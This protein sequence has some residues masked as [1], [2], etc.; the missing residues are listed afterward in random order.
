MAELLYQG[1][2][3]YRIQTNSKMV[4]YIDPFAGS[5]Y[6]LPADIVLITH[7]HFDH[8]QIDLVEKK[9]DCI[10][11]DNNNAR[12]SEDEYNVYEINDVTIEA[13]PA[14]N[15][16]H[17]KDFGVGYVISF[18][19]RKLYIT[20]D[21]GNIEEAKNLAEANIDIVFVPCDGTYTMNLEEAKDFSYKVN[22]KFSVPVH[23]SPQ[24]K[25][26]GEFYDRAIAD[27]YDGLNKLIIKP[28]ENII[29]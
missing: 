18:D 12:E 1:H 22:A 28:G 8:S 14:Y 23:T 13:V 16:Y 2:A 3:S 4:I 20:G 5:G 7:D 19:D 21:T 6:D 24:S 10:V 29:L 15:H 26:G 17:P 11:I 9:P 27:Q 25:D